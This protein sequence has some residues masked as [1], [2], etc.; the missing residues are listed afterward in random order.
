MRK[1]KVCPDD[2]QDVIEM[3]S[4]LE[5]QIDK[6]LGETELNLGLSA[7]M[8]ACLRGI[9]SRCNEK[10]EAIFYRNAFVKMFDETI[11]S[12]KTTDY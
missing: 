6:V 1:Q 12:I 5:S 4:K 9:L 3:T 10:S 8:N 2:L 7:L 11:R